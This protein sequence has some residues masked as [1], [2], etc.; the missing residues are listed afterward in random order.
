MALDLGE[1][2]GDGEGYNG[3]KDAAFE[4]AV[5]GKAY[6]RIDSFLILYAGDSLEE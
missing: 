1:S 4:V 2:N 5:G 6:I 3:S